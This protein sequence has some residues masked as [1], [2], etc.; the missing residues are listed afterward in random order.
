MHGIFVRSSA[1]ILWK[2]YRS[3]TEIAEILWHFQR[4]FTHILQILHRNPL[5][6][7]WKFYRTSIEVPL[8]FFGNYMACYMSGISTLD[9]IANK[10]HVLRPFEFQ[11]KITP[12]G[13]LFWRY[14]HERSMEIPFHCRDTNAE[15]P[16]KF[17][18]ISGE[19]LFNLHGIRNEFPVHYWGITILMIYRDI[20]I[21]EEV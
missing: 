6:I 2:F 7:S 14:L 8:H 17:C 9:G 16:W 3:S 21:S 4:S 15:I 11:N 19:F 5:E 10:A 18:A 1:E 13:H 12:C 20:G